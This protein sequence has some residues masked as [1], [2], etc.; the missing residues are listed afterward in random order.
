MA[1]ASQSVVTDSKWDRTKTGEEAALDLLHM[2]FPQK[3]YSITL[4]TFM[5]KAMTIPVKGEE[6]P[7]F[8]RK[9]GKE[10]AAIFNPPPLDL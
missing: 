2:A 4:T 1:W 7:P 8:P 6:T 5:F 10:F 3:F 9:N